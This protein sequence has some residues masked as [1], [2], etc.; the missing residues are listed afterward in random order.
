MNEKNI[1]LYTT[2]WCPYCHMANRLLKAKG[3]K[4][5]EIDVDGNPELRAEVAR[6]SG[7][8]TVPQA[9]VDGAPLGGFDELA[10]LDAKGELDGIFG[11]SS[12]GNSGV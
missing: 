1:V 11:L 7:R 8:T 9:F 3:V 4:Y 12:N 6:R 10:E 5:E 2:S